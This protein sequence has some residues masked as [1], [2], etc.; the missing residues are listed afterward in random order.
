MFSGPKAKIV[1]VAIR[2]QAKA[3]KTFLVRSGFGKM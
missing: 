3:G 2:G 1:F